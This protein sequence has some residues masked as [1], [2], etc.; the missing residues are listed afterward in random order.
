[1]LSHEN[2]WKNALFIANNVILRLFFEQDQIF[3]K[4][5]K[6]DKFFFGQNKKIRV[7]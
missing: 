4:I 7:L 3:S 6:T 1:M 2:W 5:H